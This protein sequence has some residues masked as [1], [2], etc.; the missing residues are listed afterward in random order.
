MKILALTRYCHLGASSRVRFFQYIPMLHR[1]DIN[2]HVKPLLRDEYLARLYAKQPTDWVELLHG[3]L[4]QAVGLLRVGKFDLLW[5]EKEIFPNLPAWFEQ[6]L[7]VLGVR[8]VVDYDDAIFH[9]YDLS[10]NPL[11]RL[12]S[13]K[14]D[15]VMR[16]A[17]LVVCGNA[18]L[19]EK[20][21]QAGARRV[22][23]V[24]TVIDL[25]RYQVQDQKLGERVVVGW[26]GSPITAKY[27]EIVAPA[28]REVAAEFPAQLRVI[29]AQV[30]LPGL[31]VDCR[32]WTEKAEVSEIKNFDIGIMPLVDSPWERGKCGYKLIQYMG[33]GV[34]GIASPVGV[35][36]DIIEHDVNGYLA[37]DTD[38]WLSAFRLLCTDAQLRRTIGMRGRRRVEQRFCLQ[39]TAPQLARLFYEATGSGIA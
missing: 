35:N 10:S 12:L 5:I 26:V 23:I 18:Y 19:A 8:Y 13:N 34:P 22:E 7:R 1:F 20:A 33:C 32:P 25:E 6:A 4:R 16:G 14:I 27:L 21:R 15:K 2:V 39:I 17:V 38:G 30:D 24:P 11:K 36:R 31:D 29:G 28:L 37:T 3:Y 9:N